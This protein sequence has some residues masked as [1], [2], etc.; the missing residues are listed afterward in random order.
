MNRHPGLGV[1]RSGS[2]AFWSDENLNK[3]ASAAS[4][5]DFAPGPN[6]DAAGIIGLGG[7]L[8]RLV[9]AEVEVDDGSVSAD[10][11]SDFVP[12]HAL[13]PSAPAFYPAPPIPAAEPSEAS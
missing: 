10:L 7:S 11:A 2:N 12:Y 13:P 4:A 9:L 1:D 8:Q 3:R 6:E 5:A